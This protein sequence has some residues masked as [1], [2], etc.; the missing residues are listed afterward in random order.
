MKNCEIV[1]LDDDGRR[2]PANEIGDVY[3][4]NMGGPDFTYH[5]DDEKEITPR[6]RA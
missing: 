6:Q 4:R 5:L 2:L 1:I 3:C